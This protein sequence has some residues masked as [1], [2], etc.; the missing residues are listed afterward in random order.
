LFKYFQILNNFYVKNQK[1]FKSE[2]LS[3]KKEK[4]HLENKVTW[5]GAQASFGAIFPYALE[6]CIERPR[7]RRGAREIKA[8]S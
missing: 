4:Q 1:F 5:A 6:R 7:H 3:N 8:I 2:F